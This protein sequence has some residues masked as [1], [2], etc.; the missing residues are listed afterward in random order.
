MDKYE[1]RIK[2]LK[3]TDDEYIDEKD[4]LTSKQIEKHIEKCVPSFF[5]TLGINIKKIKETNNALQIIVVMIL[6]LRLQQC[7]NI[8]LILQ[9]WT[10]LSKYIRKIIYWYVHTYI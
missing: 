6:M 10:L 5:Q 8:Y 3:I 2:D 4:V 9:I 7:I 1:N